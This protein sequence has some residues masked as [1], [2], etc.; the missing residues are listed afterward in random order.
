MKL[1][2]LLPLLIVSNIAVSHLHGRAPTRVALALLLGA[3]AAVV[4]A[5][6]LLA[7]GAFRRY[8]QHGES[9]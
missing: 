7:Y 9:S 4:G 5:A 8:R 6:A 3:A 1:A 2:T